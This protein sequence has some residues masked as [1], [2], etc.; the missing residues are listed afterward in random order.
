MWTFLLSSLGRYVSIA[1][2][3]FVLGGYS[4]YSLTKTYYKAAEIRELE[5]QIEHNKKVIKWA[6]EEMNKL[7]EQQKEL[8]ALVERLQDEA[9][10][11]PTADRPAISLDGVRRLN[12]VQ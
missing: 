2:V 12:Q 11:D 9:D 3:A 10:K 6:W 1:A 4:G 7:A 8:D 5:A